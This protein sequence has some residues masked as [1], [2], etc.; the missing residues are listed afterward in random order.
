MPGLYEK[1]VTAIFGGK[2]KTNSQNRTECEQARAIARTLGHYT[3]ARYLALRGWTLDG[4]LYVLLG[5]E[6]KHEQLAGA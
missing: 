5:T 6:Q 1:T 2:N 4:A 3:A